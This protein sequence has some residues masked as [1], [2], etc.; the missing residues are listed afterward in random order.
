MENTEEL[1][2]VSFDVNDKGNVQSM[3][4][5]IGTEKIRTWKAGT[6]WPKQLDVAIGN[7]WT[8]MASPEDL[9]I[10]EG[11][12]EVVFGWPP[13]LSWSIIPHMGEPN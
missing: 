13:V 3:T 2:W 7:C 9:D 11:Y 1:V 10:W 12:M 8:F 4:Y 6:P 5:A